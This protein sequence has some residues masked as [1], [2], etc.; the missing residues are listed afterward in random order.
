MFSGLGSVTLHYWL[1]KLQ[2]CYPMLENIQS[3]ADVTAGR[4]VALVKAGGMKQHP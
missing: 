1:G 4:K 2:V 3:P